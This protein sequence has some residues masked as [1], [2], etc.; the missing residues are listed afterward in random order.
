MT[1]TCKPAALWGRGRVFSRRQ[2]AEKKKTRAPQDDIRGK[3][4]K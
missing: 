3:D 1:R 4:T 2:N